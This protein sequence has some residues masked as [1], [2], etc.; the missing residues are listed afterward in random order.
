MSKHRTEADCDDLLFQI[1]MTGTETVHDDGNVTLKTLP[2]YG[3]HSYR[4]AK[5]GERWTIVAID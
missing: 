4:I 5:I 3:G 1:F 2:V